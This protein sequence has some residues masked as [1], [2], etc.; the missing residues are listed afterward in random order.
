MVRRRTRLSSAIN[1]GR[2]RKQ[3]G[4]RLG[5]NIRRSSRRLS[6]IRPRP[7][8]VRKPELPA[9]PAT[10]NSL[11]GEEGR[12]LTGNEPLRPQNR[13]PLKAATFEIGSPR[14]EGR[15]NVEDRGPKPQKAIFIYLQIARGAKR[16]TSFGFRI[17][18][19]F[20]S[21][22]LGLRT[23]IPEATGRF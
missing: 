11:D 15:K 5:E 17:P 10:G 14:A 12:K 13:K 9:N 3:Q 1:Y 2:A 16:V 18:D 21:S 19:F 20:R 23:S 8:R 4:H 7:F 22:D 6:A